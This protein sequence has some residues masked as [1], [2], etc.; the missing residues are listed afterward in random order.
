[1]LSLFRR[2]NFT[3]NDSHFFAKDYLTILKLDNTVQDTNTQMQMNL[4]IS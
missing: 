3:R 1:M 2:R 4:T